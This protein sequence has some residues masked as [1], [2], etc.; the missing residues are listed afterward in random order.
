MRAH[1]TTDI[2]T[3]PKIKNSYSTILRAI[4]QELEARGLK[5]FEVRPDGDVYIGACGYQDQPST[6]YASACTSSAGNS[7]PWL[8]ASLI[9]AERLA[10]VS[11]R[12]ARPPW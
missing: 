1:F 6:I 4:V 3:V 5:T 8:T 2:E 9:G 7:W 11:F 10:S 12:P